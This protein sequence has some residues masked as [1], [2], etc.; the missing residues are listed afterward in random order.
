M[1]TTHIKAIGWLLILLGALAVIFSGV[2]FSGPN[3]G[4]VVRWMTL[5]AA[6]GVLICLSGIWVLFRTVKV[7]RWIARI[8]SAL[9]ILFWGVM[10]VGSF[11]SRPLPMRD[12]MGLTLMFAWLLGL[13]LAWKWELAGAALTLAAILIQ[14]FFINWRVVVGFGMLPPITALLFL[15]C[16]WMG[17]QSR[18]VKHDA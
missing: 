5:V 4:A 3:A 11:S 10:I 8:L 12:R 15:L 14:A 17:R 16:W 18:P 6:V 7:V 13:A 2:I 1:K 9:I